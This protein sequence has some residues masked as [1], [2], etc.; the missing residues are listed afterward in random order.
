M[1][2]KEDDDRTAQGRR[3]AFQTAPREVKRLALEYG[4]TQGQIRGLLLRFGYD[5]ALFAAAAIKLRRE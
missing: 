1:R 2:F 4:L 3:V 5:H